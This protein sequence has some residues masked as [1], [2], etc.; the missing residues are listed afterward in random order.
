MSHFDCK[1]CSG[2]E[3]LTIITVLD[4]TISITNFIYVNLSF[5]Y[6]IFLSFKSKHLLCNCVRLSY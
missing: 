2:R 3:H 1:L 6:C 5:F 4:I